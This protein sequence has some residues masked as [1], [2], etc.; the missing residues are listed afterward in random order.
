MPDA[1][2]TIQIEG[3]AEDD[4]GAPAWFATINR[5]ETAELVVSA[6]DA[7]PSF[8]TQLAKIAE[9]QSWPP[10]AGNAL[11][12]AAVIRGPAGFVSSRPVAT[13]RAKRV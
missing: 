6:R 2:I 8:K 3:I 5:I 4:D 11:W 9:L 12:T 7:V 13:S 10:A 1:T